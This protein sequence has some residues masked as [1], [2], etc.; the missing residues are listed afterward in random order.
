MKI[1]Y[2]KY[3]LILIIISGTI[4]NSCS[5][6]KKLEMILVPAG[7]FEMGSENGLADEQPVH[8]VYIDSFKISKYEITNA[9]YCKFLNVFNVSP[10][11]IYK[12]VL[13]IDINDKHCMIRNKNGQFS[14]YPGKENHPVVEVSWF[15][16]EKFCKWLGGSLPTEAQWE[17]AAK[18]ANKKKNFK[19]CGSD[20]PDEVAWHDG[21]SGR[22]V[23]EVGQKKPNDI[24]IY[25][26]LGNVYEWCSD[27]YSKD[28]YFLSPDKN[29]QGPEIGKSK[30]FR[31]GW[32]GDFPGKL[33]VSD[34]FRGNQ[35][36]TG[37]TL[38]FRLC[39]DVNN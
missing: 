24:G 1:N 22:K 16:A 34:R 17:Y 38:G 6:E 12:D 15:G 10:D 14:P 4:I 18:G 31:G 36:N 21:N 25:D 19:Y 2:I 7:V 23:H 3:F 13:L 30:V 5:K 26:I 33:R 32:I 39:K 20:D 27:W 9:Q 35:K 8:K 28:Y 37:S 11:G 29:P